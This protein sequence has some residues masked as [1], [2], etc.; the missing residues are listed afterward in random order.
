MITVHHI[1]RRIV[2][3]RTLA[4][5]CQFLGEDGLEFAAQVL[6]HRLF[7]V[8]LHPGI[9]GRIDAEAVLVQVVSGPVGLEVLVEPAVE[10]VVLPEGGIH[11]IILVLMVGGTVRLLGVHRAAEHIAEVGTQAGIV[12]LLLVIQFDGQRLQAVPLGLGDEIVLGH[13]VQDVVAA[14]QRLVVV[15]H[16]I[17]AGRLVDHT[18]Q[19]G[20]L[21]HEQFGGI[22]AEEGIGCGLDSVG[23]AAEEDGVEIHR[24]D[25][26]LGVVALELDGRNPLL[27]LDT[28]HLEDAAEFVAVEFLTRIEGLGQLLGDGGTAALAGVVQEERLETH[29]GQSAEVDAGMLVEA[30]VFRGDHRIDQRLRKVGVLD[31]RAV[32]YMIG[33][34]YLAVFRKEFRGQVA[35]GIFEFLERRN[36]GEDRHAEQGHEENGNGRQD[37]PP[38]PFGRFLC[39]KK[40]NYVKG[41]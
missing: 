22:L 16:R 5:G 17:V 33:I 31:E 40:V 32:L 27:D 24:D 29:A 3:E 14:A 12:V 20:A 36:L 35:L 23:V 4:L 21:L 9:E 25:F 34:E 37:N 10:R 8:A 7:G 26:V 6:R 13:L 19:A 11:G 1:L 15:E 39:H 2:R 18:H 41:F 30:G 28:H 38:E